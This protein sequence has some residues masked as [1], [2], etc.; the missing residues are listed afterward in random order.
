MSTPIGMHRFSCER[1]TIR[2]ARGP[3]APLRSARWRARG[4]RRVSPSCPVRRSRPRRFARLIGE[5]LKRALNSAC[6]IVINSMSDMK[7]RPAR[8][9]PGG[10]AHRHLAGGERA[11]G[12]AERPLPPPRR[13]GCV[14]GGC[15]PRPLA[16]VT[17]AHRGEEEAEVLRGLRPAEAVIL[18]PSDDI[19]DGVRVRGG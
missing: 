5:P 13:L 17:L 11:E 7:A 2:R 9:L 18:Y 14:R 19:E 8:A 4:R 16:P 6:I 15:R 1:K 3:A 10:G 12:A